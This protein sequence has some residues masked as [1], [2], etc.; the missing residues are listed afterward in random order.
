MTPA[1]DGW[2]W[3]RQTHRFGAAG[4]SVDTPEIV[5]IV[6]G[7]TFRRKVV[8]FVV[9]LNWR[10]PLDGMKLADCEWAGP[11]LCPFKESQ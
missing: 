7:Y 11:V 10:G 6:M 3:L 8:P 5:R 9:A 4:V 2:Y 1:V